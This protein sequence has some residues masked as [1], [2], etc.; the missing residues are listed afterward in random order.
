M[1]RSFAVLL[2]RLDGAFAAKYP[3]LAHLPYI[4]DSKRRFHRLANAY[5]VDRGLGLWS[6]RSQ[7]GE[8]ISLIPTERSMLN[9]AQWLSNF[10]E[11]ANKRGVDLTTCS[12]VAQVQGQYQDEMVKGIWAQRGAPCKPGTVNLRVTQACEFLSWMVA[13]GKRGAFAVPYE[14]YRVSL[15]SA[16][17]SKGRISKVLLSRKGK[18][19]VETTFLQLPND[20]EVR[21]W[22][23]RTSSSRGETSALM[24][25]TILLTGIRREELVCLRINTLPENPSD[26]VIVNPLQPA[27]LQQV[28]ITIQFGTKG[29]SYGKDHGDKIGPSR[30]IH[31]P[32]S[33]ANKWHQYRRTRRNRAFSQR[34]KGITN[35]EERIA[36]GADAVH[37]FLREDNGQQ[38][39]GKR[40]YDDWVSCKIC[41]PEWSPH[42]GRHWWACSVLWRRI[43][44]HEYIHKLGGGHE[45]AAALLE[46][47]AMSVI[48][49]EIQPQ[50]GHADHATT[51][52]YLRWV[53]SMVSAPLSLEGDAAAT[54][55]GAEQ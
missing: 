18:V 47:T 44:Q 55:K 7:S 16:T 50:L 49:L 51:L 15:G 32:L 22:L 21:E 27:S 29:K 23:V 8:P 45:V 53:M 43:K 25:E 46:S 2:P 13:K 28:R 38:Y 17:S 10:L 20:V 42:G 24:C 12:Y 9:Y 31:I 35:K 5:L 30:S 54:W 33:L 34:L 19:R 3:A 40:V 4:L 41:V 11:W 6:P 36:A 48:Q 1:Q 52:R 26:W 14:S 39:T 37:L